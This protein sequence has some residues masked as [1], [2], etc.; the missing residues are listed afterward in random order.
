MVK[1]YPG[2]C[3]TDRCRWA[4][5]W[6]P[7]GPTAQATV[8]ATKAGRL[9]HRS[10]CAHRPI[11]VRGASH[12]SLAWATHKG[13][14]SGDRAAALRPPDLLRITR[15]VDRVTRQGVGRTGCGL[16]D[17]RTPCRGG[18]SRS[19]RTFHGQGEHL[20]RSHPYGRKRE[21]LELP[22]AAD[23]LR[24]R[25]GRTGRLI[26]NPEPGS[27]STNQVRESVLSSPSR[28]QEPS[29]CS[30]KALIRPSPKLPTSRS[31]L[32]RPKPA[33]AGAIPQGALSW[34]WV[35]IRVIRF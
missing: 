20:L 10:T 16:R 32:N 27:P 25:R 5:R 19:W 15:G 7:G 2:T 6:S 30:A 14:R 33:G 11:S 9:H 34:P 12:R 4:A 21:L 8:P 23:R 18:I 24:S 35:A 26:E 1:R 31:P 28:S 29:G 3:R 17:P 22:G 13:G